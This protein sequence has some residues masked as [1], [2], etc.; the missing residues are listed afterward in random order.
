MPE[1]TRDTR[2]YKFSPGIKMRIYFSPAFSLG[3]SLRLCCAFQTRHFTGFKQFRQF[4]V[5]P[6]CCGCVY[7]Y[8]CWGGRSAHQAVLFLQWVFRSIG[9]GCFGPP[10]LRNQTRQIVCRH[11]AGPECRL[12]SF[13]CDNGCHSFPRIRNVVNSASAPRVIQC[14]GNVFGDKPHLVI[15]IQPCPNLV[16]FEN[17][18]HRL[19]P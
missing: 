4:T 13:Y 3:L 18:G 10:L 19:H 12:R 6:D 1:T 5:G 16:A 9:G 14:F 17:V 2:I 8:H 11:F 15:F 7:A